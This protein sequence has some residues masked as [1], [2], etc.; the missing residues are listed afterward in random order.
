MI[1]Y[2]DMKL[3]NP[4][5]AMDPLQS[6]NCTV[7]VRLHIPGGFQVAMASVVSRGSATLAEDVQGRA[8]SRY[9]FAGD[10]ISG[11]DRVD[12]AGPYDDVFQYHRKIKLPSLVWSPCGEPAVFALENQLFLNATQNP[13]GAAEIMLADTDVGFSQIVRWKLREC[14]S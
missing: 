9:W 14:D 1:I 12:L 6:K 11:E 2:N 13:E 4:N 8:V 7:S 5:P 3:E 10:P